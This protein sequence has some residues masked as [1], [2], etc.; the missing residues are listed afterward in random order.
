MFAQSRVPDAGGPGTNVGGSSLRLPSVISKL[1]PVRAA[2]ATTCQPMTSAAMTPIPNRNLV[3]LLTTHSPT[4]YLLS[5]SRLLFQSCLLTRPSNL[6]IGPVSSEPIMLF[7]LRNPL[8]LC[9]KRIDYWRLRVIE[10][11]YRGRVFLVS[12]PSRKTSVRPL[13]HVISSLELTFSHHLPSLLALPEQ[14]PA[15]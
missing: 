2:N 4:H 7:S 11:L 6:P 1:L 13:I 3:R 9:R 15:S 10:C 14:K 8:P 5:L 12:V